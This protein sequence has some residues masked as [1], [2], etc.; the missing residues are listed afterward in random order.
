MLARI[1]AEVGAAGRPLCAAELSR[2][3][4]IDESALT[5]MLDTLVQRRRLRVVGPEADACGSCPARSGC[6]IVRVGPTTTYALPLVP[7]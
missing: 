7:S 2:D 1:L 5:G 6:F 3:L 4:G